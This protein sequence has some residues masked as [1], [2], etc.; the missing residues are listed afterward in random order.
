M[1]GKAEA[2]MREGAYLQPPS[3]KLS[4][5]LQLHVPLAPAQE[6]PPG[7]GTPSL[8]SLREHSGRFTEL[9]CALEALS[10]PAGNPVSQTH[11]VM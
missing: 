7:P 1:E 3:W 10:G 4:P 6:L 9:I 2:Q 5:S 11:L 8:P